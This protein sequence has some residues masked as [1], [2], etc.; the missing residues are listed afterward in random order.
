MTGPEISLYKTEKENTEK[1]RAGLKSAPELSGAGFGPA[2][3]AWSYRATVG[4]D[5]G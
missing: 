2:F 5:T 1:I 4:E 3:R